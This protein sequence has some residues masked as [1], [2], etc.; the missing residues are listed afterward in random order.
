MKDKEIYK[1][2]LTLEDGAQLEY[3]S[4]SVDQIYENTPNGGVMILKLSDGKNEKVNLERLIY[5]KPKQTI[6]FKIATDKDAY[7]PGD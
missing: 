2:D 5:V 7:E 1:N 4:I 6:D 3:F